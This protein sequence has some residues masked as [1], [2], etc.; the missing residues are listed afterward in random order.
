MSFQR[1]EEGR[2]GS[3]AILKESVLADALFRLGTPKVCVAF[4]GAHKSVFVTN[5]GPISDPRMDPLFGF[6]FGAPLD[7]FYDRSAEIGE[8]KARR[9]IRI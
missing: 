4:R 6:P 7:R 2:N 8:L 1:I 5:N 9:M 3:S